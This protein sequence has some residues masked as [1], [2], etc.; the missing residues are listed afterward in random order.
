MK[1]E[2]KEALAFII[3]MIVLIF[4]FFWS[5]TGCKKQPTIY[6]PDGW[7]DKMPPKSEQC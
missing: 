6:D 3:A 5:M 2:K 4:L 1:R 7:R